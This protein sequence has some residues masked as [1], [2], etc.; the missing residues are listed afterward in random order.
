MPRVT[1]VPRQLNLATLSVLVIDDQPFFRVMLTEV[2]RSIGVGKVSI[3][4]D[5]YD[6]LNAFSALRP[7]LVITDWMMPKLNGID[8]T[9]KIRSFSDNALQKVPVILVTAKNERSQVDFARNCGIDEFLLKPI[10][11]KLV[12]DRIR[13]VIE[14]PRP[15][16]TYT[17][18]IGPCRRRRAELKFCGPYRRFG[19]PLAIE[20]SDEGILAAG[21]QSVFRAGCERVRS[22]T[23][24][25]TKSHDNIRA[26]HVA[27]TELNEIAS[28]LS[29]P[30]LSRVCAVLLAYL[31]LMNKSGKS[32]PSVIVTHL[33]AL[34][35][36]LRTPVSQNAK[37]DEVLAGL[38]RMMKR[39]R[40]A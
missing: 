24:G 3:A 13:E 4:I 36:L 11:I 40:A 15:F 18:Y 20:C 25:L 31:V 1:R 35:V 10:S 38:E 12:S 22:L 17:S 30:H 6:G 19:D 16:V 23:Q 14:K 32:S 26:I 34:D 27:V 39:S 9:R 8:M 2:L 21:L 7:D 29:D 33:N 37:R 5:G 28:E